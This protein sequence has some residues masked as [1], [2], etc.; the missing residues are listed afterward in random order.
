MYICPR[1]AP[2]PPPPLGMV[3]VSPPPWGWGGVPPPPPPWGCGCW[4]GGLQ[5]DK[6]RFDY[7]GAS[8]SR[9]NVYKSHHSLTETFSQRLKGKL[10][11]S[12]ETVVPGG[13]TIPWGWGGALNP[14]PWHIYAQ[15]IICIL[16]ASFA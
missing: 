8:G 14:G 7:A 15:I 16:N 2:S 5:N 1:V 11:I 13:G 4:G 3:M 10:R 6:L 12:S 9:V